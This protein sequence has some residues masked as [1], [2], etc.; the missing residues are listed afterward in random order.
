MAW[1]IIFYPFWGSIQYFNRCFFEV[2]SV[3]TVYLMSVVPESSWY[4][5]S[6][7]FLYSMSATNMEAE[8]PTTQ[9]LEWYIT[10]AEIIVLQ[11]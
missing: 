3:V 11:M 4:S 6:A 7:Y 10:D 9:V 2:V 8:A 1:Y 5:R